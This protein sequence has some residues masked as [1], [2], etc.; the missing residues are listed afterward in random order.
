MDRLSFQTIW[1]K[2]VK[3]LVKAESEAY[4]MIKIDEYSVKLE[5]N[6]DLVT[7]ELALLLHVMRTEYPQLLYDAME[8]ENH[9]YNLL[10]ID[11]N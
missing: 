11:D 6:S 10:P 7:S 3:D 8:A 1:Y 9:L 5:G 4:Q 2:L